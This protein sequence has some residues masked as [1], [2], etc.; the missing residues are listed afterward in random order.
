MKQTFAIKDD[1]FIAMI[2]GVPLRDVRVNRKDSS[3]PMEE[4][5]VH[6]RN[7]FVEHHRELLE[8]SD[9][10]R[11]IIAISASL[12]EKDRRIYFNSIKSNLVVFR[13]L[14]LKIESA[15]ESFPYSE[16]EW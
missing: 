11:D 12:T 7:R 14:T 6:Y 5:R 9:E 13:S 1:Y 3:S 4:V 16:K 15:S 2:T 10:L 8:E